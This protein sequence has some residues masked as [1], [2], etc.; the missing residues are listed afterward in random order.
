MDKPLITQA[1]IEAYDQ[2]THLT[3]ERGRCMVALSGVC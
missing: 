3:L 1:M 2:Y